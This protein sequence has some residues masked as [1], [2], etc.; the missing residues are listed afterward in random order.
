M[1]YVKLRSSLLCLWGRAAGE[2]GQTLF[3]FTLVVSLVAFLC[4]LILS[5]LG[6]T[7]VDLFDPLADTMGFGG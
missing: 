3:E 7:I 4:V 6:L 2:E 5:A 1:S